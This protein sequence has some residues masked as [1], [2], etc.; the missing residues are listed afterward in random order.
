MS[1]SAHDDPVSLDAAPAL[2]RRRGRDLVSGIQLV[3]ERRLAAF[4]DEDFEL[5]VRHWLQE[6]A[7]GRYKRLIRY[8]GPGDKGRDVVG[9]L[10]DDPAG[11]WDNYQCKR[12]QEK[13]APTTLWAELG[14]LVYWVTQGAY[15]VPRLYTFVAPLG[16]G[17]KARELLGDPDKVRAG[18]AKNWRQVTAAGCA[19][20]TTS[21][22]SSP[23][24]ASPTSMSRRPRTSWTALRAQPPTPCSSAAD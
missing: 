9:L 12:Y 22:R 1:T 24:S 4:S 6:T 20:T 13:L 18:L 2:P 14:K 15:T 11:P 8:G 19:P 5:V 23:V 17:N 10:T 7:S 16:A 21:R 3:P